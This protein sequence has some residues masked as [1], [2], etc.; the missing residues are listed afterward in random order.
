MKHLALLLLII[1][2]GV[3]F[4]CTPD[5][6]VAVDE[7]SESPTAS[8]EAEAP[9]EPEGK[10]LT[11]TDG[12][13]QILVPE[14]WESATDLNDVAILQAE[15]PTEEQYV[16]VIQ[17]S[18]EDFADADLALHSEV[19][20]EAIVSSLTDGSSTE[21]ES[22]TINGNPALQKEISGTIDN[23]NIIYLH[24]NVETPTSYYQ[25]LT[26]S[27]RSQFEDYRSNFEQVTN[28]FEEVGG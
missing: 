9:S 27:L 18:K 21:P 14:E 28:S 15:H 1:L 11:S 5:A 25:V 12:T 6:P 3:S 22:V 7:S 10:V 13:S 23:I 17:D 20:T 24:T 8:A 19:T 2:G 4:G 16:I 26:W